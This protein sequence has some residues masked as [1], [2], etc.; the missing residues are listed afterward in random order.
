M[1]LQT[2]ATLTS[3]RFPEG[4]E[5]GLYPDS[6]WGIP[7]LRSGEPVGDAIDT[8]TMEDGSVEFDGLG[9]NS[10]YWAVA[11]VGGE[12]VYVS[13]FMGKI[14]SENATIIYG[15]G[16]PQNSEGEPG[17]LYIDVE[18]W[19][20]YGPKDSDPEVTQQWGDTIPFGLKPTGELEVHE[21]A[22]EDVHGIA[23]TSALALKS[24]L[25][26]GGGGISVYGRVAGDGTKTAGKGFTS[27]KIGVGEYRV[28]YEEEFDDVPV[29]FPV[30]NYEEPA[31]VPLL[32]EETKAS[33]RVVTVTLEGNIVD[34][35]FSF[36]ALEQ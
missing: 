26:E 9:P 25:G 10:L 21:Q 30:P 31:L 19:D 33:V 6:N 20:I 27:E 15:E 5:V 4:T 2:S 8:Q 22:T 3:N 7:G 23:D 34:M 11:Q 18:N 35:G 24:E 28:T 32:A 16:E 14:P 17:W 13:I 36:M 12:W 29:L 1:S